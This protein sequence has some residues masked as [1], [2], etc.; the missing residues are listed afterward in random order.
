MCTAGKCGKGFCGVMNN[1]ALLRNTMAASV[2]NAEVI[3]A[4][5]ASFQRCIY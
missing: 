1:V 2:I 4:G 3:V 5:R